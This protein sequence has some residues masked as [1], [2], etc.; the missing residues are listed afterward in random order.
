MIQERLKTAQ[1]HPKS[2]KDVRRRSLWFE[3]DDWVYLKVSL[4]KGVMRFG[5]NGKL[6]PRYISPYRIFKRV[7]NVE[8][9]L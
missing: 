1:C 9:E 5:K 2:Y 3:V 4:I 6:S 8:Y 7:H